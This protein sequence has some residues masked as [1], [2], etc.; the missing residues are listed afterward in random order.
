MVRDPK[1]KNVIKGNA[2]YLRGVKDDLLNLD[3]ASVNLRD[4]YTFSGRTFVFGQV[5]YVRDK[6]KEIIF[7]WAPTGG[8]GYKLVD[9]E[10]TMFQLDAGAGGV[11]ERNPGISAQKTGSI[12]AGQRFSHKFSSSA[13]FTQS[14]SSIWKTND[15]GDS[16]TNFSASI[17]TTF[18]G[19]LQL[20]LE[21]LDIYKNKPANPALKKNDTAFVTAFVLKF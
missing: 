16:L 10:S 11:I 17:T 13:S 12:T 8:F 1:T 14:L 18:V 2:S 7:F 19:S 6:F 9:A 20:K 4:E 15:F 5:D 21:F 3:R